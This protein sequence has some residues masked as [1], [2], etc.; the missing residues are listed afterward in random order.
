M[1]DGDGRETLAGDPVAVRD[2]TPP[3]AYIVRPVRNGRGWTYLLTYLR[4][5]ERHR[6]VGWKALRHFLNTPPRGLH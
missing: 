4:T 5:G 6:I 2:S 1:R 3:A